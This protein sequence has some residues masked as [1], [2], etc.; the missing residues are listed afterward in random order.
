MGLL[1]VYSAT[2]EPNCIQTANMGGLRDAFVMRGTYG[3]SIRAIWV[4]F[5]TLI[6]SVDGFMCIWEKDTGRLLGN[7]DGHRP[8]RIKSVSWNLNDSYMFASGGHVGMVKI[9]SC[10]DSRIKNRKYEALVQR[11]LESKFEKI[12]EVK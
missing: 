6:Q 3:Q 9:W 1:H 10:K 2:R 12:E 4:R 5:R 7:R 11:H 8:F